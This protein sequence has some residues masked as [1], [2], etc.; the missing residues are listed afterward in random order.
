MCVHYPFAS[1]SEILQ[2]FL[3][4]PEK[5]WFSRYNKA[6]ELLFNPKKLVIYISSHRSMY[7]KQYG[8]LAKVGFYGFIGEEMLRRASVEVKD[9]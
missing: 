5:Q 2:V 9:A 3:Q 4:S 7:P 1:P 8:A 6:N